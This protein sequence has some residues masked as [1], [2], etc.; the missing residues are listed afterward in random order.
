MGEP[1]TLITSEN[2]MIREINVITGVETHR[3]YTPDEQAA[4]DVVRAKQLANKPMVDWKF[5][6]AETDAGMPRYLEDHI[7]DD[8]DGV[9]SNEF[10]QVKYDNEKALRATKP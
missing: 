9:A 10:L 4:I 6:M 5:K 2:I 8:H 7:K 3:E 1:L